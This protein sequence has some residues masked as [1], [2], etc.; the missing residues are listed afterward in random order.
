MLCVYRGLVVIWL[1][2]GCA[3]RWLHFALLR[4]RVALV[5]L[6][7]VRCALHCGRDLVVIW[8]WFCCAVRCA[9][10]WLLF[11]LLWLCFA[12]IVL[13]VVLCALRCGFGLVVICLYF[14]CNFLVVFCVGCVLCWL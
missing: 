10:S 4:L 7:V 5:V 8:L 13:C 3:V 14:G 2:F 1:W 12:L 11:V 9:V 6:F